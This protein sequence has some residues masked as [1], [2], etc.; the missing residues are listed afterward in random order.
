M[1]KIIY[2]NTKINGNFCDIEVE[3]GIFTKFGK[4][5]DDGIDLCGLEVLCAIEFGI[6]RED[7]FAT[8]SETPVRYMGINKGRLEVG[9]DADFIVADSENK[10]RM[11]VIGGEVFK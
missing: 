6:P 5:G 7:A 1:S 11:T 9:F 3:D 8:A 2:K 4:I 10:L